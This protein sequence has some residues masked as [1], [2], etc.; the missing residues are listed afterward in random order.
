MGIHKLGKEWEARAGG[1]HSIMPRKQP[2]PKR[3]ITPELYRA[4]YDAYTKQ[5]GNVKN[6]AREA[7][8]TW[9]TAKKAWEIGFLS[10]S[11]TWAHPIQEALRLEQEMARAQYQREELERVEKD[12]RDARDQAVEARK[13]NLKMVDV[14]RNSVVQAG[15]ALLR[16]CGPAQKLANRLAAE[17]TKRAEQ[18][19]DIDVE[20]NI[21]LIAKLSIMSERIS[22]AAQTVIQ[23]DN[24]NNGDPT[25]IAGITGLPED[26]TIEEAELRYKAAMQA[27][28]SAKK[29]HLRLVNP[30]EG[31]GADIIDIG[32]NWG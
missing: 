31:S 27:I 19:E 28:E 22:R 29:G 2:G 7:G 30:D 11:N 21:E 9:R 23:T 18:E 26:L 1:A 14:S 6:A 13:N 3:S 12:Q 4:L 10:K 8:C 20:K 25:I 5:P 17:I 16:I 32:Q 15:N 24:L